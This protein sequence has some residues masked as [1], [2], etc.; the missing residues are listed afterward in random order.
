MEIK[1]DVKGESRKDL[2]KVIADTLGV[3]AEYQGMPSVAYRIGDFTVTKE[4]TLVFADEVNA[5]EVLKALAANAFYP[6]DEDKADDKKETEPEEPTGLTIEIPADK[7]NVDNLQKLL[8]AKGWLIRK[9][10]GIESLAFEVT[11][12]KVSFPWFSHTDTDLTTACTQFIAAICRMSVE[13]K[14]ITARE[15]AVT[16]EKYAFR[17]FLLRLG[18]IGDEYK[19]SRKL[20]LANLDGSSAF[21]TVKNA[22]TDDQD[23]PETES[24]D[25]TGTECQESAESSNQ[26][27]PESEEAANEQISE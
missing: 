19:Q 7:V 18:F 11:E 5:D 26:D 3:K 1:F 23:L 10:L 12:N 25:S 6:V 2:V 22:G 15:K 20:L 21:K 14:R 8:D 27:L 4:S 9:A 24:H 16:N 17:C 13:Q